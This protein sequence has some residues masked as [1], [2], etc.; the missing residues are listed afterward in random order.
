MRLADDEGNELP[1]NGQSVGE[2]EVRGPW[3]T[4]SLL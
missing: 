4:A 2:I 1:W 3:V